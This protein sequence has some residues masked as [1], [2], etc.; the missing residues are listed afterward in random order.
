MDD[1]LNV[2]KDDRVEFIVEGQM[3]LLNA[4]PLALILMKDR[5]NPFRVGWI[6]AN[7][8]FHSEHDFDSRGAAVRKF[9]ELCTSWADG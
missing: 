5:V 1:I 3:Q 6:D 2:Y 9:A 8:S 4:R 7:F